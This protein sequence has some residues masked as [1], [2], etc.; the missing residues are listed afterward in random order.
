MVDEATGHLMGASSDLQAR[1]ACE[2][3]RDAGQAVDYR[4]LPEMGHSLHGQ[5][6]E[7]FAAI[8][9]AWADGL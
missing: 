7:Q 4:S 6:P 5:D 3:V 9:T 2:I 8:L 1:R